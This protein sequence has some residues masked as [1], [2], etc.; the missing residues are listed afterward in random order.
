MVFLFLEL[1]DFEFGENAT[2]S[3]YATVGGPHEVGTW[4]VIVV[5]R[6]LNYVILTVHFV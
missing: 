5:V 6:V 3:D 4:A 2:L 1:G